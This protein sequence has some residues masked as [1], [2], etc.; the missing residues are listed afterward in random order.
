MNSIM[1]VNVERDLQ[2]VVEALVD[3]WNR[4]EWS[5]FGRLFAE[6]AQYITSAA[7]RLAGRDQ[8]CKE[9]SSLAE[10][11]GHVSMAAESVR[12]FWP[13][14]AVVLCRWQMGS[15]N[16]RA[17]LL[18]MMMQREGAGWHIVVLHNTDRAQR[19][20]NALGA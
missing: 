10:T 15:P 17:G 2:G 14:I 5:S 13:D 20:H 19:V 4:R 18:T 16:H 6:D 9:L 11:S 12:I 8:I 3:S 1:P 7:I